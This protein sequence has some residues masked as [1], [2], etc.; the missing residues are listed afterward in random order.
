MKRLFFALWPDEKTRQ[1]INTF[2]QS[3]QSQGLKKVKP[4]NLH[5]TLVFL[6]NVD[7]G[8]EALIRQGVGNI[9]VQPFVIRFDNLSYWKKPKI[10]CVST[11][12]YDPQLFVLVDAL[13]SIVGQ[14]GIKIEK[15]RYQPH[16]TLARKAGKL[17][18]INVP[19]IEWQ[20]EDFCLVQSSSTVNGVDYQVLQRWSFN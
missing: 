5:V 12:H 16:I 9:K 11:Q 4:D 7:D 1:L 20:A 18:D 13:N 17:I 2:N 14:C 6:G 10:L 8:A 15:R 3:I 19:P